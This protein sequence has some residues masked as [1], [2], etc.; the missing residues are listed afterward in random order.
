MVGVGGLAISS[1]RDD[2]NANAPVPQE[3]AAAAEHGLSTYAVLLFATRAIAAVEDEI[4][5]GFACRN[6]GAQRIP[7]GCVPAIGWS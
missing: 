1:T 2:F 5:K 6:R 7:V 3:T 4:Q